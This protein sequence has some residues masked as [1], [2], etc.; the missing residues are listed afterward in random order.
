MSSNFLN[1]SG[2]SYFWQKIKEMLQSKQD[3]L[4]AGDNITIG[5]DNKIK[6]YNKVFVGVCSS[7]END[8]VKEVSCPEWVLADNNIIVV[9]FLSG[10]NQD[11]E[12]NV[13]G[14][15]AIPVYWENDMYAWY[16]GAYIAFAY[17]A[18][19]DEF[20]VINMGFSTQN[21]RASVL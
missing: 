11:A 15:G 4:T 13:E 21:T 19:Y 16:A 12:L 18:Y 7:S 20:R 8:A 3:K 6:A 10:N 2:L 17:D 5:T 1:K 14:S 9:K